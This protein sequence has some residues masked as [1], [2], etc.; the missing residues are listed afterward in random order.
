MLL[1]D[2]AFLSHRL[3]ESFRLSGAYHVLVISGLHVAVIALFVFWV[4][5]RL[6]ASAGWASLATIAVLV[7]YLLLVEDRPPIERAVW[8]VSLYLVSRL[9]FRQVHPGNPVA[10]AALVMLFL[11]PRWLFDPSFHFS[12]GAVLLIAFL[13]V[14]WIERTS[15][16]Y[17]EALGFLDARDRDDLYRPARLAQFRHDLRAT[18]DL[19]SSLVFWTKEKQRAARWLVTGTVRVALRVWEFFLLSFAIHLGLLLLTALYFNRVVWMGLLTNILVV[20]LV[21]WIVPLGLAALLL[22][23]LW[24]AAAAVAA[25]PVSALVGLLLGV[26]GAFAGLRVSYGIPPPPP[27]LVLLYLATLVGLAVAV[28]RQRHQR[29]AATILAAFILLVAIHPFSPQLSETVLE[30]TVLDV[31]QGDSLFLAFPNGETWLIDGGRGPIAFPG[32]YLIG[33]AVGETV[34]TPYLRARGLKRLDRVWLTHAHHDH[35]TGL[36]AVLE[37]FPVGSFHIGPSPPSPAYEKLLAEVRARGIPLRRH[38]AG[39]RFGV[40]EVEVEVLWPSREHPA[41]PDPS[42]NDSLVLRL[43]QARTCVLLAGDIEADIEKELAEGQASLAAALLKVPHHGGR[44]AAG[45]E[46][47]GAV[48]PQVAIISVGATN[49]FGHPYESVLDRLGGEA[50]Q[51]F[52]TDRD[53]SVTARVANDG[54]QVGSFRQQQRTEPYPHLWAK[55]VACMRSLLPVEFR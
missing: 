45:E 26:A 28:A 23:L 14:P 12:F 8:M 50:E 15:T 52:R 17:R 30:V 37:Q 24:P 9:L 16:P 19:L 29:W 36:H 6:G 20:P 40:G 18:A 53:G 34:V 35:M 4:L 25:L 27:W 13:A 31:G 3:R 33:E 32:G 51:T 21:G 47:L 43:C 10:L 49:P 22:A 7:F 39:G 5:R 54:L 44:D 42:N 46:F 1:G 55:L 38:R 2:R 11:H 41:G 48:K